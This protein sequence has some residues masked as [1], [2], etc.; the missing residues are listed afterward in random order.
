[1]VQESW[2]NLVGSSGSEPL[3][4]LQLLCPLDCGLTSSSIWRGFSSK[5]ICMSF[6]KIHFSRTVRMRVFSPPWLWAG[7]ISS[8][9]PLHWAT[10]SVAASFPQTE[11]ERKQGKEG[12]QSL[13]NLNFEIISRHLHCIAFIS[14]IALKVSP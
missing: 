7:S 1:M 9:R 12:Y 2:Q 5:P 11:P 6:G 14:F 13:H 8:H 4:G 10:H 3:T